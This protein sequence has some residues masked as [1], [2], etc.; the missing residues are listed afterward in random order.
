MATIDDVV[1]AGYIYLHKFHKPVTIAGLAIDI[2][3]VADNVL[4][5]INRAIDSDTA[6]VDDDAF[7]QAAGKPP[8]SGP[9]AGPLHAVPVVW[10]ER[11]ETG[12][13]GSR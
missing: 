2:P 8:I 4:R 13:V 3:E 9:P 10:T 5:A 12:D 7:Y 11:E 1:Q 6:F